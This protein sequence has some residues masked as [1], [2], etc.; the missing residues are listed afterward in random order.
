MIEAK[1]VESLSELGADQPGILEFRAFVEFFQ[2]KTKAPMYFTPARGNRLAC[3]GHVVNDDPNGRV[4]HFW[5]PWFSCPYPDLAR[6]SL[7][8]AMGDTS[9]VEWRWLTVEEVNQESE[10]QSAYLNERG[11]FTAVAILKDHG[12]T[13]DAR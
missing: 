4:V 1:I 9:K 2:D 10:K 7:H 3:I 8:E 12:D 13:P 5:E 6:K 11:T